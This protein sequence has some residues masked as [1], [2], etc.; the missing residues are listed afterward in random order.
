M[1]ESTGP[2]VR[3]MRWVLYGMRWFTILAAILG[4]F[5]FLIWKTFPRP[6]ELRVSFQLPADGRYELFVA[7]R[8]MGRASI[9]LDDALLHELG[10]HELEALAW[11]PDDLFQSS[12]D[13][14]RTSQRW[15]IDWGFAALSGGGHVLHL[16]MQES[17]KSV[18]RALRYQV[19]DG[20]GHEAALW[21]ANG[22]SWG[23]S[24]HEWFY[25]VEISY[26]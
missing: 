10:D 25:Q 21:S 3:S 17:G 9:V 24:D 7:G 5:G 6:L 22:N 26:R 23:A 14:V 19:L 2:S 13:R 11:P 16:R 8:S 15:S 18:R 12:S 1:R 4:G 20:T